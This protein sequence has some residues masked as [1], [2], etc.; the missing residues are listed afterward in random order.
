MSKT[1]PIQL[2]LATGRWVLYSR[3][4]LPSQVA[5][6][7]SEHDDES[8]RTETT[9]INRKE[10]ADQGEASRAVCSEGRRRRIT[11]DEEDEEDATIQDLADG[12]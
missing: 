5:P 1:I 8:E 10:A 11:E 9:S 3:V 4:A 6:A 12:G 7:D 2:A